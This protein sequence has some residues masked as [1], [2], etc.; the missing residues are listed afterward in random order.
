MT[1]DHRTG[2]F[3]QKNKLFLVPHSPMFLSLTKVGILPETQPETDGWNVPR[4]KTWIC[5][6]D[7][8]RDSNWLNSFFTTTPSPSGARTQPSK[9]LK[10]NQSRN[11]QLPTWPPPWTKALKAS[12]SSNHSGHQ[13]H[14][15]PL[16]LNT[17][18]PEEVSCCHIILSPSSFFVFVFS[19][20][21]YKILKPCPTILPSATHVFR[22]QPFSI[23]DSKA[24]WWQPLHPLCSQSK[25][26]WHPVLLRAEMLETLECGMRILES[27]IRQGGSVSG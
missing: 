27:G 21:Q 12:S 13:P 6:L 17:L 24:A 23:T 22:L 25:L 8:F 19:Y 14:N 3:F 18:L 11:F 9:A 4:S 2:F 16:K 5:T 20:P 15:I 7:L 10:V 26:A 1:V